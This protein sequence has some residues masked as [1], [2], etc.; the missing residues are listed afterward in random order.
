M[1]LKKKAKAKTKEASIGR[2]RSPSGDA[3][4]LVA[5]ALAAHI[6]RPKELR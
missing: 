1:S 4:T 2:G 5:D 6:V 3:T